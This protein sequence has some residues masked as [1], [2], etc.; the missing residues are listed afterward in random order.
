[1]DNSLIIKMFGADFIKY[2][3]YKGNLYYVP[4]ILVIIDN[5]I[6]DLDYKLRYFQIKDLTIKTRLPEHKYGYMKL[7]SIYNNE[8]EFYNNKYIY[9]RA[10]IDVSDFKV[11][12]TQ[13]DFMQ[14]RRKVNLLT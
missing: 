6:F 11:F 10:N 13:L 12:Y 4:N 14:Y 5:I 9:G 7:T 2:D 8:M 1:M 3:E